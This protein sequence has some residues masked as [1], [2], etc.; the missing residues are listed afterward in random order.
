[1]TKVRRNLQGFVNNWDIVGNDV[2]VVVT[3]A[4]VITVFGWSWIIAKWDIVGGIFVSAIFAVS[5]FLSLCLSYM[6]VFA[7][8]NVIRWAVLEREGDAE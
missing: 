5:F 7:V 4:A 3:I 1:M 8:K 6:F 2:W